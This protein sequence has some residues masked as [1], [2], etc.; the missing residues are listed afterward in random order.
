MTKLKKLDS[1]RIKKIIDD[2]SDDSNKHYNKYDY[3]YNYLLPM[4]KEMRESKEKERN[5]KWIIC[6]SSLVYSWMPTILNISKQYDSEKDKDNNKKSKEKHLD[7]CVEILENIKKK[8]NENEYDFFS[9]Y[10]DLKKDLKRIDKSKPKQDND[11]SLTSFINNSIVG[12][13][14]FLHFSFPEYFPIWDSR[15]ERATQFDKENG[16]PNISNQRTNN[17]DRYIAYCK[18]INEIISIKDYELLKDLKKPE[19]TRKI[20]SILFY[21]GGL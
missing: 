3:T 20:E 13:S 15:V 1:K 19:K 2:H 17:V 5:K 11:D 10:D 18:S 6:G 9:N 16:M 12:T 14:K 8:I 7:R 4:F 21:V